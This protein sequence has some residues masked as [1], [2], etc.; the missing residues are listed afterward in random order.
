MKIY[1]YS[2]AVTPRLKYI[3]SYIF[4]DLL[5]I[6][7]EIITN[8]DEVYTKQFVINYSNQDIAGVKIIPE[9]ILFDKKIS[10]QNLKVNTD[11]DFVTLFHNSGSDISFDVFAAAFY[12]ISRYEEYLPHKR[13]KHDRFSPESSVAF[14][15]DFLDQ[16]V[17]NIWVEHL[18]KM[19]LKKYPDLVFN[20]RSFEYINTIDVDYA[21]AHI[22]KG[23]I[24]GIGAIVRDFFKGE[25]A[26]VISKIASHLGVRKDPFDTFELIL[27]LHRK[28]DLKSIFFFHVGDYD[29]HDKSIPVSSNK[30][31]ALIKGINDYADIGLHPS[32][33]SCMSM[34]KLKAEFSRLEK[35]VHQPII[36]S[37]FHFI[38]LNLPQSYR[39][40]IEYGAK[41][42]YTMGYAAKMGFRAGTCVPFTFYDLDYD[43]ATSLKVYPFY[44]M[45]A[46]IKYYFEEGPENAID[47]FTE[48]IEKVKKYNGTFVSLWHNDS[49][50][51]WGHWSGW[52][53]VYLKMI[54]YL[55]KNAINHD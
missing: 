22:Q 6:D 45:E 11:G 54:E 29:V 31:Q 43:E 47:Y 4:K 32:Y 53:D 8:R 27:N 15:Y 42:D 46:T 36:K 19:L 1:I 17:V 5:G 23:A 13:D 2:T 40:L 25:F 20:L 33:A 28:H 12:M 35:I 39:Q 30:L 18:Q 38:K 48:Y 21:Y 24:R 10:E 37:R 9:K 34:Q 14:K 41:E 26:E 49:L 44:L 55:A 16:P 3:T 7:S 51:E 52:R 50:S